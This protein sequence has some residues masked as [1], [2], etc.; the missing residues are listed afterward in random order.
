M[1]LQKIFRKTKR[2]SVDISIASQNWTFLLSLTISDSTNVSL[3]LPKLPSFFNVSISA[4]LFFCKILKKSSLTRSLIFEIQ[5][6]I[7]GKMKYRISLSGYLL[8]RSG[9]ALRTPRIQWSSSTKKIAKTAKQPF[10]LPV[11]NTSLP[12]PMPWDINFST[13][14]SLYN[15]V[16]PPTTKSGL[17]DTSDFSIANSIEPI[18]PSR[19]SLSVVPSFSKITTK[20]KFFF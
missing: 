4:I 7:T 5:K 13:Q 19:V 10:R 16:S 8:F 17:S 1:K 2:A 18:A 6:K 9:I 3:S 14:K 20:K 15:S 11:T 12:D